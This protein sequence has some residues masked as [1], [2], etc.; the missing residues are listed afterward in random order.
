MKRIYINQRVGDNY[1]LMD[2]VGDF[3]PAKII[4]KRNLAHAHTLSPE[5]EAATQALLTQEGM[6]ELSYFFDE[7]EGVEW[8]TMALSP[9]ASARIH[10]DIVK[11]AW[12]IHDMEM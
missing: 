3:G 12:S 9:A 2:K 5:T 4:Y 1:P 7:V 8:Q 10:D 11:A 6:S